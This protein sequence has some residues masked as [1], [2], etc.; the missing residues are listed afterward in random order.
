MRFNFNQKPRDMA[1]RPKW[2]RHHGAIKRILILLL[3]V[4]ILVAA[5]VAITNAIVISSGK[6]RIVTQKDAKPADAIIVLGA[7]VWSTGQP[8]EMLQDRLD[9]AYDLYKAGAA[10]KI[11]VSGDHGTK[12]Y[13]E[14]NSMRRYLQ[15]RGV[16][17]GNIFMDHAGF[18]TY[19]TMY[20][21]RDVF[22]VKKAIVVTQ[23]YH[24]YRAVY[25]ANSMGL[26]V[27]GVACDRYKTLKQ[28]YF[29]IR[30]AAA[31]TKD[32]FQASI[33]KPKP[34]YLGDEIPISGSGIVTQDEGN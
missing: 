31:R 19:A 4:A 16:P 7:L 17:A 2:K 10:P 25:L 15:D 9:V 20:R 6:S 23:K 14:V 28:I 27:Q 34:K 30:E 1:P 33:F 21:A 11:L 26:T 18:D 3:I 29:D 5:V 12:E 22:M 24:L 13:D 32:F 8:S